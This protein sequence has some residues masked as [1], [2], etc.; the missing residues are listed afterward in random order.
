MLHFTCDL[1]GRPVA[2]ERFVVRMEIYPAF[3][4]GEID[5]ADLDT[6]HLNDIAHLINEMETKGESPEDV[7][8][9]QVR[10]DL[11]SSCPQQFVKDPLGKQR[12]QRFNFSEN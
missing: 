8:S 1:C 5:E 10:F 7:D 11:C 6:D 3:D 9:K 12:S 4:P 2:E